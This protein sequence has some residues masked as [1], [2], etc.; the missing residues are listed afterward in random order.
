MERI[1]FLPAISLAVVITFLVSNH[2]GNGN[3]AAARS[4]IKKTLYLGGGMVL[5]SLI[6]MSLNAHSFAHLFDPENKFT[7]F[8]AFAFPFVSIFVL[9]DFIQLI[10]CG[11]LRGSGDV[12]G[13]ML[14]RVIASYI[15]FYPLVT[16]IS[17]LSIPNPLLKF[18]LIYGSFYVHSGFIGLLCIARL[19]GKWFKSNKI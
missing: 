8:S 9:F 16:F 2:I 11:T 19:K 14:I 3:N 5:V 4:I 1:A 13:V 15:F 6:I 12:K 18:I 10:L 7:D 17:W